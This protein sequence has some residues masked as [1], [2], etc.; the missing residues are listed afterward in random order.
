[1]D[2]QMHYRDDQTTI[3]DKM[4][5]KMSPSFPIISSYEQDKYKNWKEKKQFKN[6]RYKRWR[7]K[8]Q[9]TDRKR[10]R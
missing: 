1:M 8:T 7:R 2:V 10:T 6:L 3:K 4:I 9:Y 5:T